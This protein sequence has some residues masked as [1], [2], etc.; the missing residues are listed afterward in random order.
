MIEDIEFRYVEVLKYSPQSFW[1]E[2][3]PYK[4]GNA[5]EYR[6]KINSVWTEWLTIERMRNET[7]IT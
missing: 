5:L 4:V 6:K 2:P 7:N 1:F 3:K